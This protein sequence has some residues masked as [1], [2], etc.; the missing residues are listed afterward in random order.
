[1]TF[2][3]SSQSL[4]EKCTWVWAQRVSQVTRRATRRAT[5]CRKALLRTPL[6]TPMR[7]GRAELPCVGRV[8][9]YA[10]GDVVRVREENA[11]VRWRKPHL[12]TP[13]YLFGLVGTI[14]R[15]CVVRP[16]HLLP[17]M[18]VNCYLIYIMYIVLFFVL[19]KQ[20]M[21]VPTND[22]LP[23]GATAWCRF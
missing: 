21:Y 23:L 7:S 1:M 4:A 15:A 17:G 22:P 13:G 12:R 16:P 14:E 18:N 19:K 6:L 8:R 10:A 2:P 20:C 9:R 5:R 11:A 3:A